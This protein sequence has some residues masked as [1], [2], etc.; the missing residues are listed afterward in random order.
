MNTSY[1]EFLSTHP[2]LFSMAKD[3]LEAYDWLRTTESKFGML[4]CTE[5]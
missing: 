4:H 2:P 3:P 5:Y 1:L